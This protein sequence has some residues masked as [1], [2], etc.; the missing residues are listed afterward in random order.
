VADPEL[1][2]HAQDRLTQYLIETETE[3]LL[4]A[5]ELKPVRAAPPEFPPAALDRGIEGWVEIEFVVSPEGETG[6]VTVTDA[7]HDRYF[8]QEAVAAV[9]GWRFEPIVFM[10]R[11]IP[12]RSST[13]LEF[14]ID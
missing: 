10:G 6:N 2:A 4:P 8:R 3:R 5:S 12:K 13:R 1:V 14:V 11:P 7:S 9:E